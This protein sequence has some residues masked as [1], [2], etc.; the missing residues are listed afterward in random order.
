V[1][2]AIRSGIPVIHVPARRY[3]E[4]L[5]LWGG[6]DCQP[7][8]LL[9]RHNV[10][11]RPVDSEV[12]GR[13]LG[14]LLN[15][16]SETAERQFL[17]DYLAEQDERVK[18]RP[19]FPLL[20]AMTGVRCLR[21][22]DLLAAPRPDPSPDQLGDA[23]A[24]ADTLAERYAQK[25]RSGTVFNFMAA[26]TAVIIAMLGFIMP[27]SKG[28]I[29]A[30]ELFLIGGLI[31]NTAWGNRKQW[32]RRWLDYRYLAEKL[33]VMQGL[34][35]LSLARPQADAAA[36]LW[37]GRWTDFHAATLWRQ[38]A[39][40]FPTN[41]EQ[42]SGHFTTTASAEIASQIRYHEANAS[43]MHK[44]DHRLHHAGTSLFYA[45]LVISAISLAGV[46]LHIEAI[47]DA[48]K[49]LTFLSAA[50][51]TAGAA[52]F[53]LRGQGDFAGAAGRSTRTASRLRR[54]ALALEVQ[55]LT[56]ARVGRIM[57]GASRAML[58][59]LEDWR[60][61]YSHRKLLIPA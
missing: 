34:Q 4:T 54:S 13:L 33:R 35:K 53:G 43:R 40:T 52:L 5:L 2:H 48:I 17:I 59:D 12:L 47:K 16:P 60:T 58:E 27:A 28:A 25:Y 32:H 38:L 42:T 24:W 18:L 6:F 1:D 55:P 56:L 51:P 20:L 3:G 26:A 30:V 15:P 8:A 46:M 50:L 45:T 39:P 57:E 44:L 7:S 9:H 23:Y 11:K 36:V 49:L 10:P 14:R 41:E 19:E 61:A 37:E 22:T 21:Q 29:V 31:V